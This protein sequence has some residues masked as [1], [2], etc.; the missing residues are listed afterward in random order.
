VSQFVYQGG[1]GIPTMYK[2]VNYRSRLEARWAAFFDRARWPYQYEPLDLPGWIPDF[3]ILKDFELLDSPLVETTRQQAPHLSQQLRENHDGCS[4]IVPSPWLVEVKPALSWPA[5]SLYRAK[6]DRA[7]FTSHVLLVGATVPIGAPALGIGQL[8]YSGHWGP[9][10][11]GWCAK[12]CGGRLTVLSSLKTCLFCARDLTGD[13][14]RARA[15]SIATTFWKDAG[16]DTQ[17]RP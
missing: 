6:I 11:V 17:W 5:L 10:Q 4:G 13:T 2:G 14:Q 1:E 9:A 7:Q 12:A 16:N 3:A 8:R 15:T